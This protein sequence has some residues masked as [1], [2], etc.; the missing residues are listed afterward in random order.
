[1]ISVL[2]FR[3]EQHKHDANRNVIKRRE[4]Q[5]LLTDKE[6]TNNALAAR[7]PAMGEGN[8]LA[9]G[10]G[11]E[12]FP[13]NQGSIDLGGIKLGQG[14]GKMPGGEFYGAFLAAG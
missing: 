5:T 11:A 8:P 7:Q 10:G 13:L 4:V 3:H 2:C 1:M 14:A 9:Q 12:S 6:A